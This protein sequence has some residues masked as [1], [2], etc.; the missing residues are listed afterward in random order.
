MRAGTASILLLLFTISGHAS[1]Q[2]FDTLPEL[3]GISPFLRS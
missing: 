1:G 2:S 3:P